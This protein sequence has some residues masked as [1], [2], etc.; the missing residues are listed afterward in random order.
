MRL[1]LQAKYDTSPKIILFG[2]EPLEKRDFSQSRYKNI[3]LM[4]EWDEGYLSKS[5]FG[6]TKLDAIALH[7]N[8]KQLGALS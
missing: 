1:G 3:R 2:A 8:T 5:N 6:V 4:A 7:F